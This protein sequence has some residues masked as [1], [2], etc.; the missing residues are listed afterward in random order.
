MSRALL[1]YQDLDDQVRQYCAVL[2]REIPRDARR[3]AI[4]AGYDEFSAL[5]DWNFLIQR[6]RIHLKAP[7][8]TGTITYD[9]TGGS[10]ERL[11]TFSSLTTEDDYQDWAIRADSIISEID[12]VKSSSTVTLH[13]RI[14]FGADLAAG[15]S[16]SLFPLWYALPE[17]FEKFMGPMPENLWVMG[18]PMSLTRLMQQLRVSYTTGTVC[19]H[20]IAGVPDVYDRKAL[21]VYPLPSEDETADFVYKRSMRPIVYSGHESAD[22]TGTATVTAG[23]ESVSFSEGF[24]TSEHVGSVIRFGNT[25]DRPT[26]RYG[27]NPFKEERAIAS[28]ENT[29]ACTLDEAVV[30]S[31]AAVRFVVTDPVDVPGYCKTALFNWIAKHVSDRHFVKNSSNA[32][33]AALLSLR[34][35]MTA[36]NPQMVTPA[37]WGGQHGRWPEGV[38]GF[39]EQAD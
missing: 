1:T 24:L 32:Q 4:V 35:A 22:F 33:R 16:Y 23:S 20:A 7:L 6:D 38:I 39:V 36:D 2:G 13:P 11:V 28:V 12:E 34:V 17:N 37:D 31:Y 10:S 15:T 29:S 25:D 27:A 18:Q 14:N 26:G 30:N 8:T 5:Y 9:H 21:Y 3:M 19:N